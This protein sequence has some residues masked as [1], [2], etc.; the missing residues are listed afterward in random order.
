MS[1]FNKYFSNYECS[2]IPEQINKF[3]NDILNNNKI[4]EENNQLNN[5]VQ[6]F[7]YTNQIRIYDLI[8]FRNNQCL[9]ETREIYKEI[10]KQ[11]FNNED[12]KLDD[13]KSLTKC[14][15]TQLLQK[16]NKNNPIEKK[17]CF[18]VNLISTENVINEKDIQYR[19]DIITDIINNAN[20]KNE[21][22]KIIEEQLGYRVLNNICIYSSS[23]NKSIGIPLAYVSFLKQIINKF[24]LNINN[25]FKFNNDFM[26]FIIKEFILYDITIDYN[27][28][29]K[30]IMKYVIYFIFQLHNNNLINDNHLCDFTNIFYSNIINYNKIY[31]ISLLTL[32][33][34]INMILVD[35]FS[36]DEDK[37][38]NDNLGNI[39]N[40]I[41]NIFKNAYYYNEI[42][43]I[44][45][46]TINDYPKDYRLKLLYNSINNL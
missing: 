18:I 1:L 20:D 7:I 23:S 25:I 42:K 31:N 32:S 3:N 41:K 43:N 27:E 39:H 33:R 9:Q 45:E 36:I 29:F 19:F 6:P 30:N 11:K 26:D 46:N 44:I 14:N 35:I 24:K 38:N 17:I 15:M 37:I 34:I 40:I 16:Y 2:R 8:D 5:I 28:K 21:A 10:F 13:N 12:I 4:L 22:I